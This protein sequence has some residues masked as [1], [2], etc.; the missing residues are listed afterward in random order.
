MEN[1]FK[2]FGICDASAAVAVGDEY[3]IVANDEDNI[4]HLYSSNESGKFLESDSIFTELEEIDIEGAAQIEDRVY[5]MASHSRNSGAEEEPSRHKFFATTNKVKGQPLSQVGNTYTDL[6]KHLSN[7]FPEI[8]QAAEQ[9]IGPEKKGGLNIE[10]L[11][12]CSDNSLI[13][14]FRN[15]VPEEKAFLVK[16][17]NPLELIENTSA[18]PQFSDA[19]RLDLGG[20]GVRAIAYWAAKNCYLMIGGS[21]NDDPI[22]RGEPN[23]VLYKWDGNES[24]NPEKVDV[25]LGTLNPEAIVI[26]KDGKIQLL[27]DDGG[28]KIDGKKCKNLAKEAKNNNDDCEVCFF[29]SLVLNVP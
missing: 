9:V 26:Y 13:L 20:R 18:I 1:E 2:H 23:F 25:N 7:E 21:Y 29:R 15:P 16:L 11:A 22:V 28:Q 3:F 6:L 5:W 10:G 19:I 4:F 17:L 8:K 24:N 12:A 14:G 27:S